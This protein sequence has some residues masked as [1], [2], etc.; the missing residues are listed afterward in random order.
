MAVL[1]EAE[2]ILR[3]ALEV[4]ISER[5]PIDWAEINNNLGNLLHALGVLTNDSCVM[6]EAEAVVPEA[7]EVRTR[8]RP[9]FTGPRPENNGSNSA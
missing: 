1:R 2:R 8:E 4:H 9:D 7:L 5:M 6:H 3:A